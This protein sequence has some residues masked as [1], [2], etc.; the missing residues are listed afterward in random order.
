M[1]LLHSELGKKSVYIDQYNP[2]LLLPIPRALKRN[3]IGIDDINPPFYGVDIWNH[4]E[5]SWLNAAGKPIV[6]MGEIRYPCTSPNIIE[7]KSMKLYFNSLNNTKFNN[8]D[9]VTQTVNKDLSDAVGKPV[10]F[11]I[12]PLTPLT[13]CMSTAIPTPFNLHNNFTGICL[14]NLEIACDTY[15]PHSEYLKLLDNNGLSKPHE[16]HEMLYSNLLK[17]NCLVTNQPDWG[18]VYIEYSGMP[19]DHSG[20]LKYIVS[21]RNH[22]EFH[23]QCVERIFNDI[24]INCKPKQLTVYARYTRRG[25]LDINPYRTTTANYDAINLRLIRQ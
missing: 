9:E 7:S 16:V 15:L 12:F 22:N 6:A 14:D 23:E 20:L 11:T 3:E 5:I 18:S 8:V 13:S 17:S 24:L 25:G 10:A 19:I 4:Y 2:N 1:T 21:L